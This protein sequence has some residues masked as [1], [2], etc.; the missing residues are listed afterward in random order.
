M[1]TFFNDTL[2]SIFCDSE[3]FQEHTVETQF[4]DINNN[5][6]FLH[7]VSITSTYLPLITG[8]KEIVMWKNESK[9]LFNQLVYRDQPWPI[10]HTVYPMNLLNYKILFSNIQR[11]THSFLT[12]MLTHKYLRSNFLIRIYCHIH[13]LL[14]TKSMMKHSSVKRF[15]QTSLRS[16]NIS[17]EIMHLCTEQ[18]FFQGKF[19]I[20]NSD[21]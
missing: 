14:L 19:N 1:L 4:W 18:N 15:Y 17:G 3:Q 11:K 2:E 12:V 6:R 20:Y 16:H 8:N 5:T 21:I 10:F 7:Q 9:E 13:Q